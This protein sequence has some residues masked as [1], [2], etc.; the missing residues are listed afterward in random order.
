MNSFQS[1]SWWIVT[2]LLS[3]GFVTIFV[4]IPYIQKWLAIQRCRRLTDKIFTADPINGDAGVLD[5]FTQ[6]NLQA[7]KYGVRNH[8]LRIASMFSVA[9][10][11]YLNFCLY[12]RYW[13]GQ[14][15]QNLHVKGKQ[16]MMDFSIALRSL[17]VQADT[18]SRKWL[19]KPHDEM[20]E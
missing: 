3:L 8:H 11:A 20:V 19:K 10:W 7:E 14:N 1:G 2:S 5:D 18:F 13:K 15:G 16:E 17:R 4:V 9:H 12:I 6:L